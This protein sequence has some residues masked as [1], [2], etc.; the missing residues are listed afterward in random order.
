MIVTF[1]HHLEQHW[2][3][4]DLADLPWILSGL[5]LATKMVEAPIRRAGLDN[6]RGGTKTTNVQRELVELHMV[7]PRV[8]CVP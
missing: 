7:H 8:P 5:T 6:L 4:E 3:S 1:Q 2:T